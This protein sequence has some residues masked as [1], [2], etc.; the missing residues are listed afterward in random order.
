MFNVILVFSVFCFIL[1]TAVPI[2]NLLVHLFWLII[3]KLKTI[4]KKIVLKF[5]NMSIYL[6]SPIIKKLKVKIKTLMALYNYI[7]IFEFSE[8]TF[9]IEILIMIEEEEWWDVVGINS[10]YNWKREAIARLDLIFSILLLVCASFL[11]FIGY[12]FGST[13]FFYCFVF[14]ILFSK[15]ILKLLKWLFGCN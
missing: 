13:I 2:W 9:L 1:E 10:Y 7:I 15:S 11:G 4:I 14:S 8:V 6:F 5:L 12:E 3:K